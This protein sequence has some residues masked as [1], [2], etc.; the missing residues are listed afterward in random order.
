MHIRTLLYACSPLLL[1]LA[2][3]SCGGGNPTPPVEK[4]TL[5][6]PVLENADSEGEDLVVNIPVTGSQTLTL[7]TTLDGAAA[8]SVRSSASFSAQAFSGQS[9]AGQAKNYVGHVT[10]IKQRTTPGDDWSTSPSDIGDLDLVAAGFGAGPRVLHVGFEDYW[11]GDEV[12][13]DAPNRDFTLKVSSPGL[14]PVFI[15]IK[16]K[17]YKWDASIKKTVT[18]NP[19]SGGSGEFALNIAHLGPS[20]APILP[21]Q[22]KVLDP[23]MAPLTLNAAGSIAANAP[24]WTCLSAGNILGCKNT[25]IIT[26]STVIPP[27]RVLVNAPV[28]SQTTGYANCGYIRSYDRDL[29][30]NRFCLEGKIVPTEGKLDFAIRKELVKP[31][32]LGAQG[33]YTLTVLNVG[34]VAAPAPAVVVNDLM[35]AGITLNPSPP[36]IPNWDCSASTP[37]NLS[38]KYIGPSP[39]QIVPSASSTLTFAVDVAKDLQGE[40]KNCAR[41]VVEGDVNPQDNNACITN[42]TG[43]PTDPM[44]FDVTIRKTT[45][46]PLDS[47]GA[48]LFLLTPIN[49]GTGTIPATSPVTVLDPMPSGL[50]LVLP[51]AVTSNAPDW[52]CSLST[53]SLLSCKYIG[54]YPVPV[55]ALTSVKVPV[56][57]ISGVQLATENCARVEAA[58]DSNLT[59]N[60]SCV[61][62]N[63]PADFHVKL[64]KKLET[65]PGIAPTGVSTPGLFILTPSN[66]GPGSIPSGT[67]ITVSDPMPTG[68]ALVVPA[69]AGNV[70]ALNSANWDC[71]LSTSSA[72]SCKYIGSFPIPVGAFANIKVPVNRVPG[73]ALAG[74]NCAT[75]VAS[76]DSLPTSEP[77]AC[78][79]TQ[80]TTVK[81]DVGVVKTQEGSISPSAAAP[82]QGLFLLTV[83]NPG[84]TLTSGPVTVTD[85]LPVGLAL[86]V[87]LANS[88][89]VP[90]WNCSASTSSVLSCTLASTAYPF[91]SGATSTIK[92]PVVTNSQAHAQ[93]NCASIALSGDLNASND[94]SCVDVIYKVSPVK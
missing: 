17:K 65:E 22:L 60:G 9:F 13:P 81:P 28:V 72:L 55:G 83:S 19:V 42:P 88:M 93:Q 33:A 10:L 8:T 45:E 63:V 54:T 21:G 62:I 59:N 24:F 77:K 48:G 56:Q 4:P 76:G 39:A 51:A 7:S 12:N 58:D 25:N 34:T 80:N 38:C 40:V 52:D 46:K 29:T 87:G 47:S 89:N 49:L 11:G 90:T 84:S 69:A 91:I 41:V 23:V 5:G 67:T 74:E 35:P 50:S 30:N 70:V 14:N 73:V 79:P 53:S 57:R 94:K 61:P 86:N 71:T 68:L 78:A 6:Q 20:S 31:L 15:P 64:E 37:T 92:V 82:G 43:T 36:T 2:L 85:T 32:I 26:T 18:I 16:P 3:S 44:K 75:I 27:I 66:A 1:A